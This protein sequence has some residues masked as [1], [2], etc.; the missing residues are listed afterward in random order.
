MSV[1]AFSRFIL[2]LA[3]TFAAVAAEH[4]HGYFLAYSQAAEGSM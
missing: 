4:F 1:L 2:G 3:A